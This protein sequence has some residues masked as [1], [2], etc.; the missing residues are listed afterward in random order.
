[1]NANYDFSREDGIL[2]VRHITAGNVPT[3]TLANYVLIDPGTLAGTTHTTAYISVCPG[4]MAGDGSCSKVIAPRDRGIAMTAA[5]AS[6]MNGQTGD[7]K[8]SIVY[9]A[10]TFH[11]LSDNGSGGGVIVTPGAIGYRVSPTKAGFATALTSD[12]T[13]TVTHTELYDNDTR[14]SNLLAR[15][16]DLWF[17]MSADNSSVTGVEGDNMSLATRANGTANFTDNGSFIS[18]T[19]EQDTN[20]Q[21][22]AAMMVFT[23]CMEMVQRLR[24]N[25]SVTTLQMSL[26]PRRQF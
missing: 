23:S 8:A 25:S 15:G 26:S 20:P 3:M 1:L 2:D 4:N 6:P 13:S 19:T 7:L 9:A 22:A 24:V 11:V 21:I 10:S 17:A 12:N 5:T 16:T 18:N 14:V